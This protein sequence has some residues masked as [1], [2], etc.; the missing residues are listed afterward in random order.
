MISH[1]RGHESIRLWIL[2][3]LTGLTASGNT[4]PV[5]SDKW[6]AAGKAIYQSQCVDCH[7]DKGQ[8]V[9]GKYDETLYGDRSLA[10]LTR[11][12]HDTMPEDHAEKCIDEDAEAVAH[13]IFEAF[14]S[15]EARARNNPP[16]KELAHLTANQYL[17][18]IADIIAHFTNPASPGDS[19][20][21]DA[22]YYSTRQFRNE[23]RIL[24]QVDDR[25]S[26]DWKEDLPEGFPEDNEEIKAEEFSVRWR[27]SLHV[28]ETGIYQFELI[29][30]N[31]ARLYLNDSRE[32]LIDSW[33]SSGML[34]K[35]SAR[36]FL[37]GGRHYPIRVDFFKFKDRTAS[38]EL[39]WTPPGYASE[40]IPASHLHTGRAGAQFVLNTAFPPDD[41]SMGFERGTAVSRSWI[42][43]TTMAAVE[44]AQYVHDN[45]DRLARTGPD[46]AD[47][48]DRV[49]SFLE[50]FISMAF[51]DRLDEEERRFFILSLIPEETEA[52]PDEVKKAVILALKSP[53]FLY[54]S[55]G[56]GP[57]GDFAAARQLSLGLWD[58]IPD[59]QLLYAASTGGLDSMEGIL[60]QASR[61]M[62]DPRTRVKLQGF[63]HHWLGME[64]SEDVDKDPTRFPEFSDAVLS[65]MK[66]SLVHFLDEVVWGEDPD[67]R[68]L[69]LTDHIL[70]NPRLAHFLGVDE[71]A[72]PAGTPASED[73]FV[74]ALLQPESRSGVLTHPFLMTT[75][76]YYGSTSPIHRGVFMTRNILGRFL[77]PPPMAIEFMDGRFDPHLTMRE[78]V[79]ELTSRETCMACHSIINPLGFSVENFDSVGRF[80]THDKQQLIN[81]VSDFLDVDGDSIRFTGARDVGA[82]AAENRLAQLGFIDQL[83]HHMVKN[84]AAAY[85]PDTRNNLLQAFRNSEF[86]IRSLTRLIVATAAADA[87]R[88]GSQP[89]SDSTAF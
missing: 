23:N 20:G 32:A 74:P 51:V 30:E 79:T 75:F 63:F 48:R 81:T 29:T 25:I 9:A 28:P 35:D 18:T 38:I 76:A 61:M 86:N 39:R 21:L 47:Y 71:S 49:I 53:R 54:P 80:Q 13:Y 60:Q 85:G 69:L 70:V 58:S 46:K 40:V 82:Y 43:A 7:G 50:E 56:S 42:R 83:F 17:T 27:G 88:A 67:F 5:E 78:K 16:R 11:L 31:G 26:F 1:T 87:T 6:W 84:P 12:I 65:D 62:D 19:K 36:I 68:R 14:Y 59:P 34:K 4:S 10:S 57:H 52:V 66:K 3:L 41:N 15:P 44:V 77:K 24:E 73:E 45:L 22:D 55:I 64:E 8:G 2:C 72:M 33:V 89:A 37:L